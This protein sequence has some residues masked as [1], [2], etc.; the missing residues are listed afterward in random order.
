MKAEG[1]ETGS[2]ID[3]KIAGHTN[4][5]A[6]EPSSKADSDSTSESEADLHGPNM[7]GR[8]ASRSKKPTVKT[9]PSTLRQKSSPS[10]AL[11]ADTSEDDEISRTE[12]IKTLKNKRKARK[13]IKQPLSDHESEYSSTDSSDSTDDSD[14]R[15]RRKMRQT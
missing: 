11:S 1:Q 6:M 13:H 12:R 10:A 3:E 15:S 4:A 2:I 8:G 9:D 7:A 5:T 14:A